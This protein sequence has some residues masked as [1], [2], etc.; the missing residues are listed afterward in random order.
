MF[1][2]KHVDIP[3]VDRKAV[4][5]QVLDTIFGANMSP[6]YERVCGELGLPVD[7]SRLS[8][9]RDANSKRLNELEAKVVDAQENH[10]ETEVREALLAKAD[11]LASIGD[12]AAALEAFRV[13]EEKTVALGQKMDIVFSVLRLGILFE[14]WRLVRQRIADAKKM[15]EEGADWERKNRLKVYEAVLLM[16]LRKFKEAARLFLDS[17]ATFTST[18]LMT[19]EQCVF[20]CVTTSLVSLERVELRKRVIDSPEILSVIDRL[21]NLGPLINSLYRCEY[22]QFFQSLAAFSDSLRSDAYLYPHFRYYLREVRVAAYVQFL[23]SF[24]SVR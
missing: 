5:T 21:P 15:F 23:E 16:V 7:P 24:K 17:I 14:D 10:G 11:Y 4:Q 9:M 6:V 8:S 22:S 12:L 1:L 18:E 20:Y 2:L 3:G 13:T 19:Y